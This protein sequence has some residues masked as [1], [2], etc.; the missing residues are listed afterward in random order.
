M[1]RNFHWYPCTLQIGKILTQQPRS[2]RRAIGPQFVLTSGVFNMR[3]Y[4]HGNKIVN[5]RLLFGFA[6]RLLIFGHL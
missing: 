6:V 4:S 3:N 2:L 5:I 1:I